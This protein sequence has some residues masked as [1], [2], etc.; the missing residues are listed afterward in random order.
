M[1]FDVH[2]NV[3]RFRPLYNDL[4]EK[5]R[6]YSEFLMYWVMNIARNLLR[7]LVNIDNSARGF[8]YVGLWS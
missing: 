7:A 1:L 6:R 4:L 8:A 3:H 5:A 2:N